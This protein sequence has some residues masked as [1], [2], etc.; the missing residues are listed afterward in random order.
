MGLGEAQKDCTSC[1]WELV[2]PF[3]RLVPTEDCKRENGDL[4]QAM[5]DVYSALKSIGIV[6]FSDNRSPTMAPQGSPSGQFHFKMFFLS[7]RVATIFV[8]GER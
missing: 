1:S 4:L 6:G 5:Q 8:V 2:I 3:I 7:T